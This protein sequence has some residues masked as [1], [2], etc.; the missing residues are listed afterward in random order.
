MAPSRSAQ[1]LPRTINSFAMA[2]GKVAETDKGPT[3]I[4]TD[5]VQHQ[6]DDLVASANVAG[7]LERQDEE[8]PRQADRSRV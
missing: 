4:V 5:D 8:A 7:M 1:G 3:G 6:F 2:A